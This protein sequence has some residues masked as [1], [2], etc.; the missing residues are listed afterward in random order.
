M[1]NCVKRQK[2]NVQIFNLP[3]DIFRT[4][5]SYLDADDLHF[6]LRN[7]CQQMRDYVTNY[8]EWE[9]TLILLL[10]GRY[11]GPPMEAVQIIKFGGR[12]PHI[13]T[14]A[15]FPTFPSQPGVYEHLVFAA[16]IEKR[17]VIG[18]DYRHGSLRKSLEFFSLEKDEWVRICRHLRKENQSASYDVSN[19]SKIINCQIGES[20]VILFHTENGKDNNFIELLHFH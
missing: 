10:Q 14:K 4:I 5:F 19:D 12:K 13:Y 8:V 2:L 1:S 15:A 3:E 17:I 11:Q 6:N 16:T 7:T 9:Q 18:L 20:N